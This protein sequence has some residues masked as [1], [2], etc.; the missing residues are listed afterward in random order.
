MCTPLTRIVLF[1]QNSIVVIV[2][3]ALNAPVGCSVP[4]ASDLF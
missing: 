2:D 1:V 3:V 4:F